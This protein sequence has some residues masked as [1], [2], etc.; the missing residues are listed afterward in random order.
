MGFKE[1]KQVLPVLAECHRSCRVSEVGRGFLW[2][3]NTWSSG[4]NLKAQNKDINI[5][6]T[7]KALL[8]NAT[9]SSGSIPVSAHVF[10]ERYVLTHTFFFFYV[11][12]ANKH[13]EL[14]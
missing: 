6:E 9:V 3:Q 14:K 4:Q 2:A 1:E 10:S 7:F 8:L 5:A 12:I 13:N 11:I